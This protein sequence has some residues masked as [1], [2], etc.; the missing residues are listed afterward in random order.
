MDTGFCKPLA[1]RDN[2]ENI[3]RHAASS[4]IAIVQRIPEQ[5]P[6]AIQQAKI[7]APC[8]HGNALRRERAKGVVLCQSHPNLRPDP[9]DVPIEAVTGAHPT[10]G[11]AVKFLHGERSTI[12]LAQH[13]PPARCSEICGDEIGSL[14][15]VF[16]SRKAATCSVTCPTSFSISAESCSLIAINCTGASTPT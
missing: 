5:T 14:P 8:V 16:F 13:D 3:S 10:I 1:L 7:H 12:P 2:I 6:G 9:E 15:H 4:G 11:E